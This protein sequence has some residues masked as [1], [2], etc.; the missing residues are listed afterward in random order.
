MSN[1]PGHVSVVEP[2][3]PGTRLVG[4]ENVRTDTPLEVVRAELDHMLASLVQAATVARGQA[5][6]DADRIRRDADEYAELRRIEAD[7]L[8]DKIAVALPQSVGSAVTAAL[9]PEPQARA[10]ATDPRE[11]SEPTQDEA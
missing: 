5:E 2:T 4:V 9:L 6:Q 3:Q 7:S 8:R 10:H 1:L 11:P